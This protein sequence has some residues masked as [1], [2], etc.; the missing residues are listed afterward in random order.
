MKACFRQSEGLNVE[1]TLDELS[2]GQ[3]VLI[4][5]YAVLH[6]GLKPETTVCFDEPDNFVALREIEPWLSKIFDRTGEE[7]EAQ[8]LIA[9]H[10][11]ELLD[12]MAYKEGLLLDRP[13]GRHTRIKPFQDPANTGL[14][15]ADLVS[16]GWEG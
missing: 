10:H 16:R 1:Y 14:S 11:P 7:G 3:R 4:G 8:V 12:K 13:S 6:F 5:L 15:A 2:D 9:S